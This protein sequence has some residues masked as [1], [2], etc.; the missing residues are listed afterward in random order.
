M[1][2]YAEKCNIELYINIRYAEYTGI[3]QK[4][5]HDQQKNKN[6]WQNMQQK[7]Q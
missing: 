4:H 7:M 1:S 3:C 5:A 2:W 6:T